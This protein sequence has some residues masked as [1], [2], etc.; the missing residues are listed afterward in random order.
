[1]SFKVG[2]YVRTVDGILK[3]ESIRF[4]ARD[5]HNIVAQCT[6]GQD[7][8]AVPATADEIAE[9]KNYKIDYLERQIK[10]LKEQ[11][12]AEKAKLK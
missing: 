1:M 8:Q 6:F 3:I 11:L 4:M 12:E 10:G 2:D 5:V 9:F 7:Y